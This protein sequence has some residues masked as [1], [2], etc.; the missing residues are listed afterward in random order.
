MSKDYAKHADLEALEVGDV[1]LENFDTI[2][3]TVRKSGLTAAHAG[4]VLYR[5]FHALNSNSTDAQLALRADVSTGYVSRWKLFA[6]ARDKGISQTSTGKRAVEAWG[7]LVS[8]AFNSSEVRKSIRDKDA[9]TAD[10]V[11]AITA[12]WKTMQSPN[13]GNGTGSGQGDDDK[14]ERGTNGPDTPET[15][16][17]VLTT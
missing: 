2:A 12:A 3:E 10:V 8:G 5:A 17:S 9:K 4:A 6:D 7:R 14:D 11:K 15:F 13:T 16:A 1:S